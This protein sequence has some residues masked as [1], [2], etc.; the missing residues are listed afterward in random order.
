MMHRPFFHFERQSRLFEKGDLKYVILNL[1]KEK[2]SHGYE[3]IR[4]MEELF[5]GFYTPSAGSVYP[6]LQMLE[7]MSYVTAS[8]RDGK[9]VYTITE[10]GKK[11]LTEQQEVVDKIE[12]QMKDWWGPRN[13][14]DFHDTIQELHRLGHLVSRK[15]HVLAPEKWADIKETITRTCRE[16]EDILG[17]S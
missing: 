16:V 13:I 3:I 9:K 10:E 15:A 5:H 14:G 2:P 12:C 1:L 8:E 6:T 7:D 17:K 4:A 11:F